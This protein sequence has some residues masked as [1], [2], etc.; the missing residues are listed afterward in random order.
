MSDTFS[1]D[2]LNLT[3]EEI[4]EMSKRRQLKPDTDYRFITSNARREGD[5]VLVDMAAL[6][7]PE[8]ADSKSNRHK[9]RHRLELLTPEMSLTDKEFAIGRFRGFMWA[10]GLTITPDLPRKNL[11][12]GKYEVD[13]VAVTDYDAAKAANIAAVAAALKQAGEDPSKLNGLAP[14]CHVTYNK[15]YMNFRKFKPA[16]E[17][18]VIAK[19]ID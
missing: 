9:G 17:T 11:A 10:C 16:S 1:L 18:P 14:V 19:A 7:D 12:S 3:Q 8:N 15:Q 2:D 6:E 5:V 4:A 13:G